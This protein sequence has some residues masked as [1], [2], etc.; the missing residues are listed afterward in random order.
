[1]E[2]FRE[3][4]EH[5]IYNLIPFWKSLRDD[6]YGGFYGRVD[7]SGK[8]Y[9]DAEKSCIVNSRILWFFSSCYNLCRE[10]IISENRLSEAGCS[11][12][13]LIDDARY[14]FGFLKDAFVDR[15]YGG[16]VWSVT[17]D[18]KML[19]TTK[20]TYNQAFAVYALTAY[21]EA[22]GDD[23]A[24]KLA[25]YIKNSIE[26][27]LS[28]G[29]GYLDQFSRGFDRVTND[30][31]SENNVTAERT[32]NSLINVMEAY[33]EIFRLTGDIIIKEKIIEILNTLKDRM[34]NPSKD[35]LEVFFDR[36]YNSLIDLH[37]YG[38]DIEISWLLD[39]T[40]DAI[41]ER[42]SQPE[43]SEMSRRIADK[44]KEVAFDGRSVPYECE[45]GVVNPARAWWV[46]G[47]AF[48][49]FLNAYM[50]DRSRTDMLEAAEA[51][52]GF[53][54]DYIIPRT[55][56]PSEWYNEVSADGIPDLTKDIV[57]PWKG[58][59]HSGRMCIEAIKRYEE[60]GI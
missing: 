18:G 28:D 42:D 43:I 8:V 22:S 2:M 45:N 32:K 49:G 7:S 27:H 23:E 16:V 6:T 10:G 21:Y 4:K 46:Q 26:S 41:G 38:H 19:D 24:V 51:V 31:L 56:G 58:P 44:V 40:L 37:T 3:I 15:E 59:F 5:L 12:A 33:T 34:F 13:D 53:I 20:H 9:P 47:E 39:R 35:R 1:M 30:K 48:T 17:C 55:D 54:K 29:N 36:D 14:A 11:S 60:L 25:R 57:D 50:K 52:W